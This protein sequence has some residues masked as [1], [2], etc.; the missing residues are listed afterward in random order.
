MKVVSLSF[1]ALTKNADSAI[2][3]LPDGYR[4]SL[5]IT[6]Y[7]YASNN[8]SGSALGIKVNTNGTIVPTSN[9]SSAYG[10]VTL[11]FE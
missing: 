7:L 11:V 1:H 5:T 2:V 8:S 3:T 6:R 10:N 4:P 9:W